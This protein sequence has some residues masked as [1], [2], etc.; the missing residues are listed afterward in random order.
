MKHT[1]QDRVNAINN[2]L[3][4]GF[5]GR[6]ARN[7]YQQILNKITETKRIANM[8]LS[9]SQLMELSDDELDQQIKWLKAQKEKRIKNLKIKN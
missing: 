6:A 4:M 2:V 3:N 9:K 5:K 8:K 7:E 1:T